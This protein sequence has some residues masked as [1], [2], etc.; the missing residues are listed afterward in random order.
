M[1]PDAISTDLV[2]EH[3]LDFKL[4]LFL[5]KLPGNKHYVN[6]SNKGKPLLKTV[7]CI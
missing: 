3:T 6:T 2:K 4:S 1:I 7:M 5:N